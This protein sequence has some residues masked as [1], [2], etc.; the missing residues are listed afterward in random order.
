MKPA[1]NILVGYVSTRDMYRR[2]LFCNNYITVPIWSDYSPTIE[3]MC[4]C[5]PDVLQPRCMGES[6]NRQTMSYCLPFLLAM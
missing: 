5:D 1:G 4:E 6:T 3:G 2:D